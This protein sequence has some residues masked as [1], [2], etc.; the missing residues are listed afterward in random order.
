MKEQS[1]LSKLQKQIL[2]LALENKLRENRDFEDYSYCVRHAVVDPAIYRRG[3]WTALC[4]ARFLVASTV[5][6]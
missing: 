3:G 2:V 5:T 6:G 4:S 1:K